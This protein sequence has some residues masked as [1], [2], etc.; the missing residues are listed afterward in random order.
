MT[1]K[2]GERVVGAY[3]GTAPIGPYDTG[4][5]V[6]VL[7]MVDG[8]LGHMRLRTS[9]RPSVRSSCA[10]AKP[11]AQPQVC[12]NSRRKLPPRMAVMLASE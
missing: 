12:A 3:A 10:A 8:R 5:Q 1:L 11:C 2:P 9:R 6:E 7:D 4:A